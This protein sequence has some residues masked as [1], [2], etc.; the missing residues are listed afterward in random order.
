MRNDGK[1]IFCV[2]DDLTTESSRFTPERHYIRF[3]IGVD[4]GQKY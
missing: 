2:K 1:A 3:Q 4:A